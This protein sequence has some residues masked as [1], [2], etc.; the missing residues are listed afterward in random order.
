MGEA[1]RTPSLIQ[2]QT[3]V[4]DAIR[5]VNNRPLTTI[6]STSDD[7]TPLTPSCFL[8]QHLAPNTPVNAFFDRGDLR[9][10]YE[11]CSTLARACEKGGSGGTSYLSSE[12]WR[13]IA[14]SFKRN[15]FLC[16]AL[17]LSLLFGQKIAP[18]YE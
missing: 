12:E 9:R 1:R 2:L 15:F 14:T 18:N 13:L 6:S 3:F 4:S 7:L 11:Y 8:G 5:I 17:Y 10:D 16:L